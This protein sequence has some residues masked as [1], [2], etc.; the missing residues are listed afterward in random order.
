MMLFRWFAR[1]APHL[2]VA[3]PG[4]AGSFAKLHATSFAHGW[5]E[6]EFERLLIDRNVLAHRASAG[7]SGRNLAFILSRLAAEEA[8]ILSVA[9]A[10]SQRRRG[11]GGQLLDHHLRA[12]AG[13][14]ARAV[15]LEVDEENIA[16]CRLYARRHFREVGRRDA[17][18]RRPGGGS[19]ALVLR[20]DFA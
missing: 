2:A 10:A 9:V 20:R 11:L 18:Y 5:S 16:A 6:D 17:Y 7:R 8:E 1:A 4:D 13:R 15:F 3:G 19:R 14:G 12:L